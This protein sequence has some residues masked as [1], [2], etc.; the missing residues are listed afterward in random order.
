[1]LNA[2]DSAIARQLEALGGKVTQKDGA[3]SQ[4]TFTET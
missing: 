4:I 1:L 3:V 2:D